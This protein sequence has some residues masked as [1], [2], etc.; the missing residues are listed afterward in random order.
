MTREQDASRRQFL[1]RAAALPLALNVP[2]LSQAAVGQLKRPVR[3]GMIADL[4]QDI[5]HDGEKRMEAFV[6]DMASNTPNALLQLGD[7]AYPNAK[8]RAVIER[9]NNAHPKSLHVIGNHDTDSG[10]TKEQCLDIWGM[11][12]RY[13]T[14]NIDGLHIV[15]LD[16]NDTGSPDHKGGYPAYVGPE[17]VDWLKEQ[18]KTLEGPIMVVSHQ[19]LA[20]YAAV[21]NAREIQA[22]LEASA[23]KVVL[24]INGHSHIDALLQINGIAYW[25]IN[26]ASYQWVGG[27]HRHES[28]AS[29]IHEA[30]PWIAYTCPYQDA[31]FATF[32]LDPLTR[33]IAI[34]GRESQWVGKTPAQLGATI[35][36]S[37]IHGEHIVPRIRDRRINR[38]A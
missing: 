16:G 17:Q 13:Y 36:R 23:D 32:K 21:D 3:I 14:A 1:K 11:P 29:A 33:S 31:L 26:S 30:F 22:I 35:S 28:Y 9:F 7:F 10:H 38:A 15:V 18:L 37:L 25:H 34:E 8:N 24:A 12:S 19:P 6:A 2:L 20:G 5:M 27:D 4:H